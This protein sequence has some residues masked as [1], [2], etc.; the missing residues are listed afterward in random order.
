MT[1]GLG[2]A[3]ISVTGAGFRRATLGI[4]GLLVKGGLTGIVAIGDR[5]QGW[6]RESG[7][8]G[9]LVGGILREQ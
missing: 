3:G 7:S 2:T 5:F 9:R 6:E 4:S 1:L 8:P